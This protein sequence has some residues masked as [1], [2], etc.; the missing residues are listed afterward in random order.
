MAAVEL[1][2]RVLQ[3]IEITPELMILRVVPDGWELPE[4]KPGQFTVLGLPGSAP[5]HQLTRSF[6]GQVSR[7]PV[8]RVL[9]RGGFLQHRPPPALENE[10]RITQIYRIKRKIEYTRISVRCHA[11]QMGMTFR[12]SCKWLKGCQRTA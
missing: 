9:D 2:A 7:E 3:R 11:G 10:P 6:R 8:A 5:R 4:F 1:N 12:E